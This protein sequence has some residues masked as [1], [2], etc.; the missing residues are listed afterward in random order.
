MRGHFASNRCFLVLQPILFGLLLILSLAGQ[1]HSQTSVKSI[2][3][4]PPIAFAARV[5]GNLERSRLI[6][7]FDKSISHDAYLLSNPKRIVID[8]PEVVFSLD[9]ELERLPK[10]LVKD[11][12]FGII[13]P[14]Q[15]RIVLELTQGVLIENHRVKQLIGR[16]RHRLFVDMVKATPKQFAEAVRVSNPSL[17]PKTGKK[18]DISPANFKIVLDP[19]HGGVDGG[20]IGKGRT[21]EKRIT[22]SFAHQLRQKLEKNSAFSVVMTRD[23]DK[24]V[25]LT[26]RVEI[27]RRNKADLMISI[28]A[29]SLKQT[30]IRGATVYTLSREGSDDISR[31]LAKKQNKSDLIAG[32]S[33][34][35]SKPEVSDILIDM[36]R[37][38]TEVFSIRFA[39]LMVEHMKRKIRLIHNP[40]RSADFYVLK[41]PEIPSVLLELGYLSNP[42]D[43]I[44]MASSNWQ[45]LAATRAAKAVEAF[46]DNR[47]VQNK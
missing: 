25:S 9:G 45:E 27:A 18:A 40:H 34:P 36:T 17:K 7:D 12:R 37:R 23:T 32:L 46:F 29:D 44:L 5:I 16:E 28:H 8:L 47:L 43:E 41:A 38:E 26:D 15:S 42:A 6:V 22:L 11:L 2:A 13:A 3:E 30:E 10:S 35:P 21:N 33:L 31:A 20:A 24:F 1:A 4:L 14:G 19:G 39:N